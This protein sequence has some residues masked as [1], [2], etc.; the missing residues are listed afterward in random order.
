[1]RSQQ[2]VALPQVL[3]WFWPLAEEHPVCRVEVPLDMRASIVTALSRVTERVD[4]TRKVSPTFHFVPIP[5]WPGRSDVWYS[6]NPKSCRNA[7]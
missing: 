3:A 7:V 5:M 1:M 2:T 6:L 4:P